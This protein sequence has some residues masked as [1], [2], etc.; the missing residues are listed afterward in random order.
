M[1]E[2]QPAAGLGELACPGGPAALGSEPET[3]RLSELRVIDLRAEL[4]RRNLDTGGNKSVLMERLRKAIEDEG[5]DPDEIPVASELSNK[6][7][8]KRM[9]K[10]RKPE[11]E[12]VEDN[13]LE[14]NSRDGQEDIEASLDTLQ[15]IDMMDISVLD[16]AE[17]DNSSAVDCGEDYSPDNIL[18]S[19]SDNKDNI[20]AEMKE[21]P[22]Q[23]TENEEDYDEIENNV[24]SSSD[25]IEMKKMEKLHLEPENEKILDILGETCKSELLNEETS[26]AEQ[27]RAQ[28]ASNVVPGTRLAEEED[29]LGAA[30]S[31]EDALDLD[32]KSA[33]AMARKEAKRLVVAKGETSEQTLEEEKLDSDSVGVESVSDQSSKRCQGLEASSGETAE[34]GAG[35]EGK[36]SREDGKKAEDKANAEESP[37]TKESSASEGADQKKSSVEE[38]RDTK[39]ISK[40]EK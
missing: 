4:K 15:D 40:D 30:Q 5:G 39:L 6:R 1:A 34:R 17:I 16:E 22:D 35:P 24:D 11:E 26:E 27:P 10:G 2:G 32:S 3:R 28:E 31:E 14:E 9:S 23:L 36:D 21:L 19:L 7:L 18:D 37:A 13:G 25:L 12:G 20:D 8:S 38:D 33:Q 29:A